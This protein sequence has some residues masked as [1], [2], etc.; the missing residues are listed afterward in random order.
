M[1]QNEE[2]VAFLR[3]DGGN[4]RMAPFDISRTINEQ[5]R[6]HYQP[7]IDKL[8]AQIDESLSKLKIP[9]ELKKNEIDYKH[10]GMARDLGHVIQPNLDRACN[11]STIWRSNFDRPLLTSF[12]QTA[13]WSIYAKKYLHVK[14][15]FK[16]F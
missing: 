4:R 8:K 12:L 7:I 2:Q 14:L 15:N 3:L 10:A 1:Y 16:N 13:F 9:S 5:V 6:N 11:P